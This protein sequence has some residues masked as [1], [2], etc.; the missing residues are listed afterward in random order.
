MAVVCVVGAGI[1]RDARVRGDV[2]A[3]IAKLA[4][5][6]LS[7][8]GSGTAVAAVVGADGLGERVRDLHRTFFPE[9]GTP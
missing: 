5:E 2:L 3:A 7:V 4:P 6:A 1:A 9:E 8:G